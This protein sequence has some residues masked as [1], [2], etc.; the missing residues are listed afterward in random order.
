MQLTLDKVGHRFSEGP[1]LFRDLDAKLAA[2]ALCAVT[3]ASGSGKSTL[4]SI[5]AGLQAPASGRVSRDGVEG[6]AWVPQVPFGV[7]SRS[8]LDH[9]VFPLIARGMRRQTAEV[10]A[11][12]LLVQ[13]G[14]GA[15]MRERFGSL[16]GG[17]AQRLMLARACASC[18]GLLLVDE[19]TA[20]LDTESAA[21]VIETL[22]ALA[23]GG[24]IVVI[25]T[26]D[27]R[28]SATCAHSIHLGA[29]A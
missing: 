10:A 3:G 18:P 6:V 24:R 9:V 4:L 1:W 23:N 5:L 16:S 7:A 29:A 28:V 26:H 11:A 22:G 21:G 2:G 20:Q 25:A 17:E 15:V 14:L 8:A 19:P 13:F 27:G 12:G